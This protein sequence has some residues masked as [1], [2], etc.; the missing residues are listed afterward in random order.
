MGAFAASRM[1]MIFGWAT[2]ALMGVVVAAMLIA[3]FAG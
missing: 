3:N 2:T 1:Q